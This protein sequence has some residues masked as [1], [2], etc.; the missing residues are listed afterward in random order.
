MCP[1]RVTCVEQMRETARLVGGLEEQQLS[2]S[3]RSQLLGAFGTWTS[4][5]A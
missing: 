2:G 3:A 4:G 5:S 1:G